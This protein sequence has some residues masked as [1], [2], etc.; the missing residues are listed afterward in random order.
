MALTLDLYIA[1][2]DSPDPNP[3]PG[4]VQ[5]RSLSQHTLHPCH[6]R[7]ST[8][9]SI[10]QMVPLVPAGQECAVPASGYGHR[11]LASSSSTQHLHPRMPQLQKSMNCIHTPAHGQTYNNTR[12]ASNRH[13][14]ADAV[15]EAYISMQ[16]ATFALATAREQPSPPPSISCSS[17]TECLNDYLLD[18]FGGQTMRPVIEVDTPQRR[19]RQMFWS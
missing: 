9:S 10:P 6:Q 4:S 18:D 8:F 14:D 15:T 7:K 16:E 13:S 11:N 5:P 19:V 12:R 2:P 1:C 17:R 3:G